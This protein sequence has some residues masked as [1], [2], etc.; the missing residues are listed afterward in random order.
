MPNFCS[1]SYFL[2]NSV[3]QFGFFFDFV[4]ER[5]RESNSRT[6]GTTLVGY[7]CA[8]AI[9]TLICSETDMKWLR[10]HTTYTEKERQSSHFLANYIFIK[11]QNLYK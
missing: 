3:Q 11:L 5:A 4:R 6:L 7:N 10:A 1:F 9:C 2:V 8:A